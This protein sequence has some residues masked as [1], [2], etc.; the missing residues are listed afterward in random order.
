MPDQRNEWEPVSSFSRRKSNPAKEDAIIKSEADG[1]DEPDERPFPILGKSGG[2]QD[3]T[4]KKQC[5][6]CR[7][8]DSDDSLANQRAHRRPFDLIV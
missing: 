1:Y 4:V 7:K 2:S 6:E 5:Q 3:Q 8:Y